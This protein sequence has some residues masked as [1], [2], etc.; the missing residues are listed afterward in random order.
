MTQTRHDFYLKILL[1]TG[2][3]LLTSLVIG[4]T[5]AQDDS[6]RAVQYGTT[7]GAF[8]ESTAAPQAWQFTGQEREIIQV[9]V[10]RISGRFSPRVDLLSP[11][12]NVLIPT[13]ETTDAHEQ[14]LIFR[15]GLPE[16]G[17]YQLVVRNENALP[18]PDFL[19]HEYSLTL[20]QLGTRRAATDEG[21]RPLPDLGIEPLPDLFTGQ[22]FLAA[23][24]DMTIYGEA[25]LSQPDP[26]NQRNI[27]TFENTVNVQLNNANPLSREINAFAFTRGGFAFRTLDTDAVFFTNQ[28][29]IQLEFVAGIATMRLA[30]NQLIT[31]DFY[32][33]A[34]I[35]AVD[36]LVVVRMLDGQRILLEGETIDVRR[37]GGLNGEGPNAE[38]VNV[39][40]LDG[41]VIETDL[42]GWQTFA[43][44]RENMGHYVRVEYGRDM[45]FIADTLN[46][47]LFERGNAVQ[48]ADPV[49][50]TPRLIEITY[51]REENVL[52]LVI[53]PTGMGDIILANGE[54]RVE[55]L[56]G[57]STSVAAD[58]VRQLL[59]E[60][61]G[62][63][64]ERF[65]GTY[66][67]SLPDGTLIETPAT[68][69]VNPVALPAHEGYQPQY[70]NNLG[71]HI[72]DYH[73]DINF[74]RALQPVN[75]VNGNF[76]YAVTEFDVPSHTLG[77]NWT[78]YYNSL[79]PQSQTPDYIQ[80]SYLLGQLGYGW[81]HS[82]QVE[83]DMR[84]APLGQVR[85]ILPDGGTYLF[86]SINP[87]LT[88]FR[89]EHLLSWTVERLNGLTGEWRAFTTEGITYDFDRAGR[90][91]RITDANGLS[92][93]FSPM[94]SQTAA[95]FETT[96]GFI[97][98]DT[99]GRH[100][101]IYTDEAG[102]IIGVRG[103]QGREVRY[104]YEGDLLIGATY[105]GMN[106]AAA[107]GY[108]N[109]ALTEITDTHSPYHQHM[110]LTYNNSNQVTEYVSNPDGEKSLVTQLSYAVEGDNTVVS[111]TIT[112]SGVPA[113]HRWL[114]DNLFRLV[115]WQM[116]RTGWVV[117]WK[118]DLQSER[119]SEYIMPNRASL[120]FAFDDSGYLTQFRDPVFTSNPY[121][122]TYSDSTTG[123]R[124]LTRI[125]YPPIGGSLV[126]DT[127]VYD[128]LNRLA[129]VIRP[130]QIN[131]RRVE[132]VTNYTYD[133]FGRLSRTSEVLNAESTIDTAY[134]YD[135]FGYIAS[136][137]EG[138]DSRTSQLRHDAV[139]RLRSVIDGRGT[140]YALAWDDER[141]LTIG[142]QVSSE[143]DA[144]TLAF[145]YGYDDFGN[146]S[147][148][149]YQGTTENYT[150]D[151]LNHL[152]S[153]SD[154]LDRI[155]TYDY[156]EY[157]S[158]LSVAPLDDAERT[159]RYTYDELN[160]LAS[161]TTASGLQ[162]RYQVLLNTENNRT[163]Q[164]MT[165]STGEQY[166]Y[167]YDAI[168]R[169]RQVS[170]LASPTSTA[171][172]T[173]IFD[174]Q[175][176]YNP[177]GYLTEINEAHTPDGRTLRLEYDLLGNVTASSIG[178]A[179]TRYTYDV[180]GRLLTVTDPEERST[181]YTYDALDNI[182]QI[183][184]PDGIQRQFTYDTN[185]NLVTYTNALGQDYQYSYDSLNRLIQLR[186]P[187]NNRTTYEYDMRGNLVSATDPS[188]NTV[189]A[190]YDGVDNLV[191]LADA[192]AN[193]TRF[194][195]N[196]LDQLVRVT[197]GGGL[198][199][200]DF[201]YDSDG[202][203]TALTQP[204]NREV[205]YGRDSLGRIITQ[206]NSLG[207]TTSY[208]YN[209]I[210]SIGRIV[211]P[212][213]N[214]QRYNYTG[215][216]RMFGFSDMNGANYTYSSD[217]IGRL[218]SLNDT[219]RE[220]ARAVNAR[221][222]YDDS[223]YITEIR[224]GPPATIAGT[225]A[226]I[227]A[228]RYDAAGR[229][230]S[231]QAPEATVP[232]LFTYDVEGQ[233]ATVTDP[234][235]QIAHYTYDRAGNITHLVRSSINLAEPERV[236]TFTYDASGRVTE[237]VAP[238][239][240][241]SSF[242]YDADG[243]LTRRVDNNERITLFEYDELGR[244]SRYIDASG[245]E[246]LYRY[247]EFGNIIGIER[248][249]I[250][251][252]VSTPN[253]YRFEY[254]TVNNLTNIQFPAGEIVT[255]TYDVLSR[256]VRYIGSSGNG[257]SYSYDAGGNLTQISDPL[258]N[259]LVYE[260]DLSNRLIAVAS[261]N[262]EPTTF[263]YD[264]NGH[265]AE[266]R[267]PVNFS[268][269]Q[270]QID[271]TLDHNGNLVRI[272]HGVNAS[273][274]VE[275]ERDNL[276]RITA[277]TRFSRDNP[278]G[279]TVPIET[280]FTYNS[281]GQIT[282]I[283]SPDG[284]ITREYDAAGRLLQVTGADGSTIYAYDTLGQLVGVRGTTVNA[285]Y[286]YDATGHLTVRDITDVGRVEYT[287]DTLYRPI[288]VTINDVG[289]NMTYDADGRRTSIMRD[290]GLETRYT[291]DASGRI[292]NM[293]HINAA[294]ERLDFFVYEYDAVGNIVRIT[295]GDNTSV[296]YSYD[297]RQQLISERWLDAENQPLY[298]VSYRYDDAGNRE[299]RVTR[300]GQQNA[301]RTEF[302]YNQHNQL[303]VELRNAPFAVEQRLM[304][305]IIVG[306]VGLVPVLW[307]FRRQR[308]YLPFAIIVLP[309]SIPFF[310]IGSTQTEIRYS[311]D[312]T[313]TLLS[314]EDDEGHRLQYDYDA[315]N[316]LTVIS[317]IDFDNSPVDLSLT[318]DAMGRVAAIETVRAAEMT[319][320]GRITYDEVTYQ[321]VY[322]AFGLVAVRNLNDDT[323]TRYFSALP[324]EILLMAEGN[325][326]LYP[327]HD[328]L[329]TLRR[330][331][332]AEGDL[333]DGGSID[334]GAFGEM[335]Q[336]FGLEAAYTV[337]EPM[338]VWIGQIYE[339]NSATYTLGAR[340]YDPRLG[341][342]LQ[343]DPV[344]HDPQANLYTYAYNRPTVYSDTTGLTPDAGFAGLSPDLPDAVSLLNIESP[345]LAQAPSLTRVSGVQAVEN[346]R[347]LRAAQSARY[348]MNIIT[349]L[350]DPSYCTFYTHEVNP[351]PDN[352][353]QLLQHQATAAINQFDAAHGWQ[354][355]S[356][357][358]P[359]Q[360]IAP[361]TPLQD[362]LA[363]TRIPA[364]QPMQGCSMTSNLPTIPNPEAGLADTTQRMAFLNLLAET[365]FYPAAEA[366]VAAL[367]EVGQFPQVNLP[368]VD[369]LPVVIT[370]IPPL[371][372][373]IGAMLAETRA[374]YED[375]LLP[376]TF[377]LDYE[378]RRL[379]QVYDIAPP[380]IRSVR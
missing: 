252:E 172:G 24:L 149:G 116:P 339:P 139:G 158:L 57:R 320:D 232:W 285:S 93:L 249:L 357:P 284:T 111:E 369:T 375:I 177:L 229:L 195:Y 347:I 237:Y 322:D 129:S 280:K 260:Y 118:Y 36:N 138:N 33:V 374:F 56:D 276:G 345:L 333:L 85:L 123:M 283:A 20:E 296:L 70:Y 84:Y 200:T 303:E 126:A 44:I 47:N 264:A 227:H 380:V 373:E 367:L 218:T 291:Y 54:L 31:T 277:I 329:G 220:Q 262:S 175:L 208:T 331:A 16:N 235:G 300:I 82:Y 80:Q 286:E 165:T 91:K 35:L 14:S 238:D 187:E 355:S 340:T 335:L 299:E 66:L 371:P 324:G 3:F 62:I 100:L 23:P 65:D 332:N 61:L 254:D 166:D 153:A 302:A 376:D 30:N 152:S 311:Y 309:L 21:V 294:G 181:D 261:A 295:R 97:V 26:Q 204:G 41:T 217:G 248:A 197:E 288:R 7:V 350:L 101:G 134:T 92:L 290:N 173:R 222:V 281:Q 241:R 148:Y 142:L 161:S 27:F 72:F 184:A 88:R 38:P 76:H 282:A 109:N 362:I 143:A 206:T 342:F 279:N 162:T 98:T 359:Q 81:R 104:E 306:I 186:D 343:R 10:R 135:D 103:V 230:I 58:T 73:P 317:G 114:S 353:G 60:N 59:I 240:L 52:P 1:F 22:S 132:Q 275:Y 120:R 89:S 368:T 308:R 358:D 330:F 64:Y 266:V 133:E 102:Q 270:E 131:P 214:E 176:A 263:G 338:P 313:G 356:L 326:T 107:Y 271:Y 378:W 346:H 315:F 182:V 17:L 236:E 215:S 194:S 15:D 191:R 379:S 188:N 150:Y 43:A 328:A 233:L 2:C 167:V 110:R 221:I 201:V 352:V 4:Q 119:L 13:A 94:P 337:T 155:T 278:N 151:G 170:V 255:Q 50:L 68:I 169:L 372:G 55:P 147:Q 239:G 124:L 160:F 115:E 18:I 28:D 87:E 199:T 203:I 219:S 121:S 234:E 122:F 377:G 251:D 105:P 189:T 323:V 272:Q 316:R 159:V 127:F 183:T 144:Q 6:N 37:R 242:L 196:D 245:N 90:L 307:L 258:G 51:K 75:L 268:G 246:T 178:S 145:T 344:R 130:V 108:I 325:T 48:P 321:L 336:P 185:G 365:P 348:D 106:Q 39:F 334:V 29:V 34:E 297:A 99:Y 140:R 12:G 193:E 259:S 96:T 207:Y 137:T 224:F 67:V 287:Y 11:S 210:G 74:T 95:N 354:P 228:Y 77:L 9:T 53:D 314:V 269:E 364:P 83:L 250:T 157:G 205:L 216:A 209:T 349:G 25:T 156:D 225:Q 231:Y 136:I 164:Q 5:Q 141:D 243:R 69:P 289:I 247:D 253:A 292:R 128:E 312:T 366:E 125:D 192:A 360:N 351:L 42:S 19:A 154:G 363:T 211:N 257:W 146:L 78:R 163:I 341:R 45:R 244:L 113:T 370:S 40:T 304:L 198:L 86:N 49:D 171:S 265:L 71:T 63:R 202:F 212:L 190:E 46:I 293:L 256:R 179:T 310:Q 117:Q 301:E 223:G 298:A 112:V 8:F 226:A 32:R 168:G 267:L 174:Y 305:P 180:L 319:A 79:A 274:S 273:E 318:Y 327:L 361:L 213:G